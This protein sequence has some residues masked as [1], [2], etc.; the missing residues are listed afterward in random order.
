MCA[1]ELKNPTSRAEG[2]RHS[3]RDAEAHYHMLEVAYGNAYDVERCRRNEVLAPTRAVVNCAMVCTCA[4]CIV[5]LIPI[6]PLVWIICAGV[7][8]YVRQF[9]FWI[10]FYT[11]AVAT[12]AFTVVCAVVAARRHANA[13]AVVNR[14]PTLNDFYHGG[15]QDDE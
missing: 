9:T 11:L 8:S 6:V 3:L 1:R 4:A 15:E 12:F 13:L 2:D 10:L 5:W 7:H 14:D